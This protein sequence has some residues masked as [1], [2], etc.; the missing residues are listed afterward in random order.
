MLR[1]CL[2]IT[3]ITKS[4][5]RELCWTYF[6]RSETEVIGIAL[7]HL[8]RSKE[9]NQSNTRLLLTVWIENAIQVWVIKNLTSEKIVVCSTKFFVTEFLWIW[10]VVWFSIYTCSLVGFE[11]DVRSIN[12][13]KA[14]IDSKQYELLKT[15]TPFSNHAYIGKPNNVR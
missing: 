13:N 6:I 3:W 15:Y 8:L 5:D 9:W 12:S 14:Y 2:Y 10:V 1:L 11:E 4:L 7:Y